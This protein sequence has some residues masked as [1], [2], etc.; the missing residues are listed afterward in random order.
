MADFFN[1]VLGLLWMIC[2][3]FVDFFLGFL[4]DGDPE[5]YAVIDGISSIG[6]D[7]TF[8]V[9]YF[10]DWGAVMLCFGVMVTV[11]LIVNVVKFM[12]HGFNTA[13]EVVEA[14]PVVE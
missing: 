3:P 14:I 13:R 5:V 11:M 12:L 1:Y 9:F 10:C 7:M 2:K 4:P 6:S 8:N